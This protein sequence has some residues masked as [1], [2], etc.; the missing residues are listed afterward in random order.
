MMIKETAGIYVHIPF[1]VK[2]CYYCDF[3][4][5][6][7]TE[8]EKHAYVDALLREI[9]AAGCEFGKKTVGVPSVF[10]G[11]GTPSVLAA[12]ETGRILDALRETFCIEQDAE[13]SLEANPKTVTKEKLAAY[14]RFGINRLSIGVQSCRDG[15]LRLL[16]R[17][18]S[19]ADFLKTWDLVRE[20]G[21]DNVNLDLMSGLPGQS[22]SDWE[23][24]LNR[25]LE[26]SPEH[27]SAYSLIIE[28]GT[29]FADW[30]VENAAAF[31]FSQMT[32]GRPAL[33]DEETDRQMYHR[34]KELLAAAGY[35]R[36]EISN[37][38]RPG[39][40]CRHN[41]RYW[42]GGNYLGF[43]I[44]AASYWK[45][46]RYTN[47]GDTVRYE[48]AMACGDGRDAIRENDEQL[49]TQAQMEEFMFLGLRCMEGIS[50]ARFEERFAVP[51]DTVYGKVTEELERK[52]LL[53]R[54][55]ERIRL[56]EFGIDVSNMVLA[57][58]LL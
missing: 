15:E 38:A 52:G 17:V 40:A 1:C 47:T 10:F 21:F 4:S 49:G 32:G 54:E 12:A 42:Q 46:C 51:Y 53:E 11:G 29:P 30:F 26:L 28:E 36:Y 13:I 33:P 7:A 50:P 14:R 22:T 8:E 39:K 44:G 41:L 31:P 37:Y 48:Q 19:F 57:E 45:G 34:T 6:P 25:V 35:E 24:T 20:A 55:N 2:K 18:H 23:E 27:I 58:F 5:A 3:L 16:G 56:T 43:G 9:R